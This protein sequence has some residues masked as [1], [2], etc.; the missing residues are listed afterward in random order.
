MDIRKSW[1]T[2][3][4]LRALGLSVDLRRDREKFASMAAQRIVVTS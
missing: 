3:R 1:Q 4:E 2:Y